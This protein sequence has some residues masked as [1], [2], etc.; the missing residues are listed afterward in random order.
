[1]PCRVVIIM[2]QITVEEFRNF[3]KYYQDEEH[4]RAGVEELYRTLEIASKDEDAEWIKI[5]RNKPEPKPEPTN[6]IQ[7][8]VPYQ[9]Q[10]DN[11]SGTGYRE[12]FSSSCAMVAMYYGKVPNDDEYNLVRAKYGDSTDAGAQVQA[13]RELGLEA[14]FVTTGTTNDI[15]RIIRQGRPVPVGWLHKGSVSAP[16]GG[17]HWSVVIGFKPG[18]WTVH[19]PNG[20][21]NL[22]PG[23]YAANKNGANQSYSFKNFNP[24]WIVG[25]EGDGWYLDI[26]DPAKK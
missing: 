15:R 12:C 22:V 26:R 18:A 9:S 23:G 20:E 7:L 2:A 1:M 25:G 11:A 21:A 24:R 3:F 6:G 4:Q 5:Y 16:S 8:D 13:L 10:L 17:G 19:D 14:K